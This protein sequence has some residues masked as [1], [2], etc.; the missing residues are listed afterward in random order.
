MAIDKLM[1]LPPNLKLA[2]FLNQATELA[3]SAGSRQCP[4]SAVQGMI[5]YLEQARRLCDEVPDL[6]RT[7]RPK[8]CTIV[9]IAEAAVRTRTEY[10]RLAFERH[11]DQKA[12]VHI[13]HE[14]LLRQDMEHASAAAELLA[15]YKIR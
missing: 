11:S 6:L 2:I 12:P 9:R 1:E 3:A 10:N 8:A 15:G 5:V 4:D 14:A 13:R 7:Y